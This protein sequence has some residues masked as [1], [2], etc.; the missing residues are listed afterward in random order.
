MSWQAVSI[1]VETCAC[2]ASTPLLFNLSAFLSDGRTSITVMSEPY[3]FL[4]AKG[5]NILLTMLRSW[6]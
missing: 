6:E 2:Y 3:A 1:L 4:L 5:H